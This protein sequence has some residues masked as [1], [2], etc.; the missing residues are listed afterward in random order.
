M[1]D[2]RIKQLTAEV[3]QQLR[4][5]GASASPEAEDRLAALEGRVARI[6]QALLSGSAPRAAAPSRA[7]VPLA[8]HP[9]LAVVEIPQGGGDRCVMEPDKP[10]VQSHACRTFGH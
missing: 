5:P 2:S 1:D 10:C 4:G 7:V 3:M 6:E 9:S 8:M